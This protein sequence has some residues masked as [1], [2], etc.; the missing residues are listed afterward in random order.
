MRRSLWQL[1]AVALFACAAPARDAPRTTASMAPGALMS[2]PAEYAIEHV[3]EAAGE[4]IFTRTGVGDPYRTGIPYPIF[5][6]LLG[7]YP[8]ELGG[9]TAGFVARFGFTPRPAAASDGADL[10]AREALPLGMHLTT[11]PNTGVP[12]VVTNCALCHSEIVRWP[13]GERL[14]VGIGS[15]RVR[16]HAYD[17]A[18]ARIAQ[19]PNFDTAHL[20]P[21]STQA[22]QQRRIDWPGAYREPLVDATVRALRARVPLRARFL[23]RVRDGLPGRVA[24]IESFAVAF[25]DKLEREIPLPPEIGWAKIPDVIGFAY[26]RTLSFDGGSEGSLDALVVDADIAAGARLEWLWRHPWQGPSLAAFL[27]QLPRELRFPAPVDAALARRGKASFERACA[28]CHGTYEDDGRVKRYVEKIVPLDYVDSDPA[29]AA[30]VTDDFVSAANDPKLDGGTHLIR[31]RRTSGYV[32]PV[33]TSIWAR[34]PYGHAGQWPSLALLATPPASRPKR[35]VVHAA[36][37]LDLARVG[38]ATSPPGTRLGDGDYL[39]D[40]SAPGFRAGGH[41]FLAD[42]GADEARAVIEY[43]K[44]L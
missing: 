9:T 16:I 24:T 8:D 17:D 10:D 18:L 2:D 41:P 6:A 22:A 27:R 28:K 38:V 40:A 43:L 21:L 5:L 33:L 44:T 23:E 39:L 7:A 29:R 14:V 4:A 35:L 31:T 15:K 12:F 26:R 13:G 30:A 20:A 19:R 42:L 11:D 32:P 34:A 36:A 37:P 1:S 25:G 3:S